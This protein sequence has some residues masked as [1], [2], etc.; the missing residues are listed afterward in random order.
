MGKEVF[1]QYMIFGVAFIHCNTFSVYFHTHTGLKPQQFS[2]KIGMIK[3]NA[4][5]L[6]QKCQTEF[7][8]FQ[9]WM[10]TYFTM[11]PEQGG[12]VIQ[13]V[14][15]WKINIEKSQRIGEYMQ[16]NETVWENYNMRK[17]QHV[18]AFTCIITT[19]E[20]LYHIFQKQSHH[21]QQQQPENNHHQS[22]LP[23]SSGDITNS[24]SASLSPATLK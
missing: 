18:R 21:Q 22:Y 19:T 2:Y 12:R 3:S 14:T 15:S 8:H 1:A 5:T 6:C 20:I 17:L 11:S 24:Y 23:G 4:F 10:W 7:Y 16:K 13:K 9:R